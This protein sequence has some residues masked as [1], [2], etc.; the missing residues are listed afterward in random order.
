MNIFDDMKT[1]RDEY[2]FLIYSPKTREFEYPLLWEWLQERKPAPARILDVGTGMSPWPAFLASKGYDV[3]AQDIVAEKARAGSWA[4]KRKDIRRGQSQTLAYAKD[5]NLPLDF[6]T[7]DLLDIDDHVDAITAVS[8]FEHFNR[9]WD[10]LVLYANKM[11]DMSDYIFMSTDLVNRGRKARAWG[12]G[13]LFSQGHLE[14]LFNGAHSEITKFESRPFTSDLSLAF[15]E[16]TN[17]KDNY[18]TSI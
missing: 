7:T 14:K 2:Q 11:C 5:H 6:V 15:L 4:G 16:I 9:K 17:E 3:I 1:I 13:W 8:S 18:S 10:N 12:S